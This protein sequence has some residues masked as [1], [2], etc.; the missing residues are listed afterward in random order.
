MSFSAKSTTLEI[1]VSYISFFHYY[2][3]HKEA[4]IKIFLSIFCLIRNANEISGEDLKL[5]QDV[6]SYGGYGD[7]MFELI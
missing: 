5:A 3:H 1:I 7:H 6:R 4:K 2:R